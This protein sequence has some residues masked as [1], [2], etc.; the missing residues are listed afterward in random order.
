[1]TTFSGKIN[2]PASE[3]VILA[4]VEPSERLILW[5]NHAG[6][7]YYRD[8]DHYVIR[9][10]EG[11]TAL[12]ANTSASLSAS[13]YYFDAT[14]KRLYVRMSDDAD[15]KN[16]DVH[17]DYRLFFSSK[18]VNLPFNLTIG[19]TEVEYL[20]YL[21]DGSDLKQALDKDFSGVS[22][23]NDIRISFNNQDGY[24]DDIFDVLLWENKKVDFYFWFGDISPEEAQKVFSGVIVDKSFSEKGITFNCK[25]QIYYLRTILD[26]GRYSSSDGSPSTEFIGKVKRRIYG[27]ADY[28]RCVPID[29]VND[30]FVFDAGASEVFGNAGNEYIEHVGAGN[31]IT[32]ISPGDQL[33]IDVAGLEES[34]TV[35]AV[36][37]AT[38]IN[39]G[40]A[41]D[42]S[43]NTTNMRVIPSDE[44]PSRFFNREWNICGHKL[45]EKTTTIS[46]VNQENRITVAD[47]TNIAAGSI[48]NINSQIRTVKRVTGNL[49]VLNQALDPAP[50]VS[51]TVTRLP[52]ERVFSGNLEFFHDRDFTYT[53]TVSGCKI[54]FNALAEFN[55]TGAKTI[56]GSFT[57]TNGSRTVSVTGKDVENVLGPRSWVINADDLS[58]QVWYE[59]LKA[60][61]GSLTLR[62]AYA[63]ATDTAAAKYKNPQYLNDDSIVTANVL[64]Y[65]DSGTWLKTPGQ[66]VKH[67]VTND[68]GITD[69]DST[70]FD[71]A[72]A[73]APFTMSI[74]SPVGYGDRE[75]KIRDVINKVNKSVFGSLVNTLAFSLKYDVLDPEKP[76]TLEAIKDDDIISWSV[77]TKNEILSRVV[78]RYRHGED[79]FN[80][81]RKFTT[82]E[83]DNDFVNSYIG[84]S[85]VFEL[86][87]YLYDASG[88]DAIAQRIAFINSV[89]NSTVTIRAKSVFSLNNLNDTVWLKLDRLY[90]RFANRDRA[91]IAKIQSI[92][93]DGTNTT[94]E[95]ADLGNSFNRV[96]SIAPNTANDFSSATDDEKIFNCYIC[97]NTT[98]TPDSTSDVEIGTNLIG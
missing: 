53:N 57:F 22:L 1:M 3:K 91:K 79:R 61:E 33:I 47:A 93:K 80:G 73:K 31:F 43:F 25:D 9:A 81:E 51:D 59:V 76:P 55:A 95:L 21:D 54:V 94:L 70:S 6:A 18:G 86:D 63:G 75:E 14:A 12:V 29:A 66:I 5:T 74:V 69:I 17:V 41:L 13:E 56:A 40:S 96:M 83:H 4:H 11:G 42:F 77:K 58:H 32:D 85:R 82:G 78:Y 26:Y 24:F 50:S 38:K 97:D 46:A 19:S 84:I 8:V 92:K 15:P 49:I 30:G 34:L 44:S 37:S 35:D 60:E 87:L 90:K 2:D 65:D 67:L 36:E 89:S 88:A 45:Y 72:D 16:N 62:T 7:V 64:G 98:E 20:S 48:L 28:V 39:L 23:E 71:D 68:G 10:F 52:I 27:R